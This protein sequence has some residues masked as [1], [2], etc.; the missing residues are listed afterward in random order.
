MRNGPLSDGVSS[1]KMSNISSG[2]FI[3]TVNSNVSSMMRKKRPS[4]KQATLLS[5]SFALVVF[6]ICY[7]NSSTSTLES[8]RRILCL[9]NSSEG[10]SAYIH[11]PQVQ[12]DT[13][14]SSPGD[15]RK[16]M[17]PPRIKA[18]NDVPSHVD[19]C[20]NF[21]VRKAIIDQGQELT[22]NVHIT[23]DEAI[24]TDWASPFPALMQIMAGEVINHVSQKYGVTYSHDCQRTFEDDT[25]DGLDWKTVQQEFAPSGLIFDDGSVSEAQVVELCKGCLAEFNAHSGKHWFHTHST[26]HCIMYPGTSRPLVNDAEEL[27]MAAV[28]QQRKR[29]QYAPLAKLT[30]T[31]E[32][33]FR[34]LAAKHKSEN[35][36]GFRLANGRAVEDEEEEDGVIIYIDEG[37]MP[38]PR[39]QVDKH[40]PRGSK[41]ISIII[42]ALCVDAVWDKGG[43]CV[44]Y[45][46]SLKEDLA[47][48][49]PDA[50]VSLDISVSTA[51]TTS[52]MVRAH[53]LICPP[54]TTSCLV[55]A[56]SK[57]EDTFAILG[58]SMARSNT[59]EFFDFLSVPRFS[60]QIA[61]VDDAR[62]IAHDVG[63]N[64]DFSNNELLHGVH[65]FTSSGGEGYKD[66]CVE[67][68]GRIGEWEKDFVYEDLSTNRNGLLRGSSAEDAL[69][70]EER[71]K[72][73]SGG[74][75]GG[76]VDVSGNFR[77]WNDEN[78]ECD[79]D[80]LNIH[81]MCEVVHSMKLG[82]VQ[83][84][85][86]EYTEEMVKSFWQ[87]L[88]I[89]DGD[90]GKVTPSTT[91]PEK[92]RKTAHCPKEK[93][94]FDI[95]FT[96]NEKLTDLQDLQDLRNDSAMPL[97]I[98]PPQSNHV[99]PSVTTPITIPTP[100][101]TP[102]VS[103]TGLY[104]GPGVSF[105][106]DN[107]GAVGYS[108]GGVGGSCWGNP[109][110]N[111]CG[112]NNA[113]TMR[114]AVP[115]PPPPMPQY[116]PACHCVPFQQQYQ[117]N[118]ATAAQAAQP[119]MRSAMDV[120]P[121]ST[122]PVINT[123][124][125]AAMDVLPQ[126]S[127]APKYPTLSGRQFIVGAISPKQ[128]YDQ[129][130]QSVDQ[131]GRT[132]TN[133]VDP[134]DIV[135]LRTGANVPHAFGG[136]RRTR[137]SDDMTESEIE[138]ANHYLHRSVEEYR[139][140]TH[141]SDLLSY[142]PEKSKL[143][144]VHVLDI[145]HMTHTHPLSDGKQKG[146]R[147]LKNVPNLYDHWNHLLY[148]NMRDMARAELAR[149]SPKMKAKR[150]AVPPGSPYENSAPLFPINN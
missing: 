12:H 120:L 76:E 5:T 88:G 7:M 139:R 9:E 123:T 36:P 10:R 2:K 78:P 31:I 91:T 6:V 37:S 48:A 132:I 57:E 13:K 104:Q 141:Q 80:M 108:A 25:G 100:V 68:R 106:Y 86:D 34:F 99:I 87:L 133:T 94:S 81:G 58:E 35:G 19:L 4:S 142:D 112:C 107:G 38:M 121:S 70:I 28:Q 149:N 75:T 73:R 61:N 74:N 109:Y 115:P 145:T 42:S 1:R 24:C 143:P 64:S 56:L 126:I 16:L 125:H 46:E 49:H 90:V 50:E 69:P 140:R 95:A 114:S 14:A 41:V 18:K 79:M 92:Y 118:Y 84:V 11:E 8:I 30:N 15:L 117:Y 116:N 136:V 93:I 63:R 128:S 54:G 72:G 98:I 97:P 40:I 53:V 27:D 131:F 59:E 127:N 66:G 101:Y 147:D 44:D 33:R 146:H 23:E 60:L 103:R 85:G 51:A 129:F 20:Q 148:S 22:D 122:V 82:V 150:Q 119:A 32:D 135:V 134:N 39:L 67:L 111:G 45:A 26:R 130:V 110:G 17:R 55:P 138:Q 52:R 29:A 47:K 113:A 3:H 65:A 83:F 71:Q 21:L 144:Y 102:D 89:D 137:K 62:E 105:G 77:S 43:K 124:P 96:P